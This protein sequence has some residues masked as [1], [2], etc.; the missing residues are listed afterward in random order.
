RRVPEPT[1]RTPVARLV[2]MPTYPLGRP[3]APPQ[4]REGTPMEE[5]ERPQDLEAMSHDELL[6]KTPGYCWPTSFKVLGVLFLGAVYSAFLPSKEG[7][8]GTPI[9]VLGGW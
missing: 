6:Q 9:W 4:S 2:P 7:M 1:G 5:R 3:R 8:L